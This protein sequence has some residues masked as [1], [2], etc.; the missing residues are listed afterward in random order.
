M[1]LETEGR[2]SRVSTPSAS[3]RSSIVRLRDERDK[4]DDIYTQVY[5]PSLYS[6]HHHRQ[7]QR[8][9]QSRH[10]PRQRTRDPYPYYESREGKTSRGPRTKMVPAKQFKEVTDP[11]FTKFSNTSS[12]GTESLHASPPPPAARPKNGYD[13]IQ[14]EVLSHYMQPSPSASLIPE[15][16]PP[17][18]VHSRRS[19]RTGS[20][21]GTVNRNDNGPYLDVYAEVARRLPGGPR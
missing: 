4:K 21:D 5:I 12:V 17:R 7:Q 19:T 16:T 15:P 1:Y 3:R 9:Q 8:Y 10:Q 11:A 6:H 14:D 13:D 20:Y 2:D 18:P